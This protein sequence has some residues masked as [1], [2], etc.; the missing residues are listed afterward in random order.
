MKESCRFYVQTDLSN[1]SIFCQP[2]RGELPMGTREQ[3]EQ[4]EEDTPIEE[5]NGTYLWSTSGG[6]INRD[7]EVY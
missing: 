4:E 1:S 6:F 3:D 2:P 7:R 5:E